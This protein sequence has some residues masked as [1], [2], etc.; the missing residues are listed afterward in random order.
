[1]PWGQIVIISVIEFLEKSA[2]LYPDKVAI[3]DITERYT[4][5]ELK[6][7]SI[8][9]S[10]A[11]PIDY[12]RRP[13]LILIPK[14][15]RNIAAYMG[16]L[17]SGNF[18][19]PLD[20]KMP[21]PRLKAI[22][23]DFSSPIII[24]NKITLN[25]HSFL[26]EEEYLTILDIDRVLSGDDKP[27]SERQFGYQKIIDTEPMYIIYTS[28]STGIPKGVVISH[29][30]VIDY[31]S[32]VEDF[33]RV[34]ESEVIG[35]QSPFCFDM[36]VLDIY[37]C[38]KSGASLKIIPES[39]FIFLPKLVEFLNIHQ[40]SFIFWVPTAMVNLAKTELLKATNNKYLKKI[41]FAGEAMPIKFLNVWRYH[42]QDAQ[43]AN[44]YGP[45]EITVTT[46]Y[47]NVN[48]DFSDSDALPIGFPRNNSD[49]LVLNHQN[50][51]A[52]PNEIGELCVRGSLLAIGYWNDFEKTEALFEQ[53]PLN[54]SYPERVYR[55]GD[56]VFLNSL[57]ELVLVGRKDHQIKH[58]GNRVDLGEIETAAM[59]FDH[60]S[61]ACC[62]Y[63]QQKKEIVLFFESSIEFEE[64]S[65]L[66]HLLEIIPKY[67]LPSRLIRLNPL[68]LNSNTKIDRA[69]LKKT[70]ID[71]LIDSRIL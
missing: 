5:K 38:L 32:W 12:I 6:S 52:K 14:S 58:L 61:L 66:L 43:F 4:F 63:D 22:L 69:Y 37:L 24:V 57:G 41:L 35:S 55:T 11:L 30:S 23:K 49:I 59:Q 71:S 45:T 64:K 21:S 34:D 33:Y 28:G 39:Y 67:M 20:E 2:K 62:L 56:L 51:I 18:Y 65:I 26:G 25:S 13:I 9:V 46:T 68:P 1:V 48:K 15:C 36:S 27:I 40:V 70:Y 50:Q 47:Y 53:N 10:F 7:A 19:V 42:F 16:V 3:E 60:I 54:K 17:Y 29:R 31:I 8:R 44:L